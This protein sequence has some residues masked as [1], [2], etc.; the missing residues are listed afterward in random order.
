[1]KKIT[2]F[3]GSARKRH[4]HDVVERFFHH[5]HRVEEIDPEIVN[6]ADY[7]I[8]LCKGC[9]RCFEKGE[10]ACPLADDRDVL[11][12]KI[13]DSNGVVF[14][15]PSY[16][17]QVSALMKAL[18]DRLAFVGHRPRFFGKTYTSIVTQGLFG[19]GRIVK[20]LDFV[21]ACMGFN[22][23]RGICITALEP[24]TKRESR[25][26]DKRLAK[27]AK[28]FHRRLVDRENPAP[29]LMMLIGFRMGRA[30]MWANLDESSLD[31]RYYK[32]RGWFDAD[33][34]YPTRLGPFK[35]LVGRLFDAIGARMAQSR[36]R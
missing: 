5:L 14:A 34:F 35:K 7:R 6:L 3:V 2:A 28:R 19:G 20:Y 26:I 16:M 32:E 30:S 10:E 21:G 18:L 31:F 24:M 23:V 12:E 4:T 15:S 36:N 25:K 27:L 11:I 33:Y 13:M 22:T 1:M 17:F 9:K 29:S 8:E